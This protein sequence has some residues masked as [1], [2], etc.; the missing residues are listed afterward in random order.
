MFKEIYLL[1]LYVTMYMCKK[2]FLRI[3]FRCKNNK[4]KTTNSSNDVS[5]SNANLWIVFSLH[6]YFVY[7]KCT[8]IGNALISYCN[9]RI[10]KWCIM[11]FRLMAYMA[12]LGMRLL[13]PIN[14]NVSNMLR[15]M[16]NNSYLS[17]GFML[18]F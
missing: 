9:F 15:P 7:V 10:L 12:C 1:Y 14:Q 16:R 4:T 5:N 3:L 13:A 8:Y 6:F 18:H 11:S 17:Y 2:L